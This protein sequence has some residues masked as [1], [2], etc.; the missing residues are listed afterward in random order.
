VRWWQATH[1]AVED[2]VSGGR[3]RLAAA[4]WFALHRG[5]R[6][7]IVRDAVIR[8]AQG[9]VDEYGAEAIFKTFETTETQRAEE[10]KAGVSECRTR[11]L[12]QYRGSSG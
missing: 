4:S 11:L 12:S 10:T 1:P 9:L 6:H 8:V 7:L 3:F 2:A 5:C